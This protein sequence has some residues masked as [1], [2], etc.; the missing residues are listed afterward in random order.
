MNRSQMEFKYSDNKRNAIKRAPGLIL[1]KK[2]KKN[3]YQTVN[4]NK[5]KRNSCKNYKLNKFL[6]LHNYKMIDN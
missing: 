5:I 2:T 3:F 6:Q 4:K 1:K